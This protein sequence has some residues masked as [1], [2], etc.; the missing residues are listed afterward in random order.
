MT[1]NNNPPDNHLDIFYKTRNVTTDREPT[2]ANA[3]R[4]SQTARNS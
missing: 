1:N 4:A 3:I 2:E